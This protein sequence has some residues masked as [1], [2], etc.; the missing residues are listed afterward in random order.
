MAKKIDPICGMTVSEDT[1]FKSSFQGKEF[2]FCCEHCKEKF[3]SNPLKFS[4]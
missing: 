3:D 1:A 4:R 2:F